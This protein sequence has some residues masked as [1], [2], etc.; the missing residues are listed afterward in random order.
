MVG[1]PKD[2]DEVDFIKCKNCDSPCYDFEIDPRRGV[3]VE[4]L[5]A[6]CGNDDPTAFHLPDDSEA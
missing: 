6:A 5:C 4:A 3:I 2:S 1:R